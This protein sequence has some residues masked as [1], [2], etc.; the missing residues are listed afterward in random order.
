MCRRYFSF[1]IQL[2]FLFSV[3]AC[4]TYR[5][6]ISAPSGQ[7]TPTQRSVLRVALFP[8]I[9]DAGG[10]QY[11]SLMSYIERGFELKYPNIDLVLR[12]INQADDFYDLDSLRKWLTASEAAER[13]DLIEVDSVLLGDLVAAGLISPWKGPMDTQDWHPVATEAVRVNDAFY[14][15]PHLLCGHFIIT[16]NK[17]VAAARNLHELTAALRALPNDSPDL[18]GNMVGSWNVPSLFLDLW[19]DSYPGR[20]TAY[21]LHWPL[22]TKRLQEFK[23]LSALCQ[24]KGTNPCLDGTFADD[25]HP[26][27]A[28]EKFARGE[29]DALLGYSERLFFVLATAKDSS[30]MYI[31]AAPMGNGNYPVLFTDAFV[32]RREAS[33]DVAAAARLFATFMNSR[34]VQEAVMTSADV[35]K[36]VPSRYLIPATKSAFDAPRLRNDPFYREIWKAIK[37]AVPFPTSGFLTVRKEIRDKIVAFLKQ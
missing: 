23:E 1:S 34:A 10:D 30:P 37:R 14:G 8:Y 4:S 9:P 35:S 12:P 17:G 31:T 33:D 25:K 18:V 32:L 2:C 22:E 26:A 6:G 27:L 28:A 13:F 21:A 3:V 7:E 19:E 16:R 24:S 36:K 15:I 11:A 5:G 20:S 29:A